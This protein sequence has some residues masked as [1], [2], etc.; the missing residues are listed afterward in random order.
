LGTVME[1]C[2]LNHP[3][4]QGTV[5]SIHK[6]GPRKKK[7]KGMPAA[8]SCIFGCTKCITGLS[9]TS[10]LIIYLVSHEWEV[11][12]QKDLARLPTVGDKM[13]F[14]HGDQEVSCRVVQV[15]KGADH[16]N[17]PNYASHPDL[18]LYAVRWPPDKADLKPGE[19]MQIRRCPRNYLRFRPRKFPRSWAVWLVDRLNLVEGGVA[20]VGYTH[21]RFPT[22][23]ALLFV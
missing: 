22:K 21:T 19:Q 5:N 4:P 18:A 12:V 23:S 10:N 1:R 14:R 8:C 2:D 16:P 17:V 13:M 3:R 6:V 7:P 11:W 15:T 9:Q 20:E